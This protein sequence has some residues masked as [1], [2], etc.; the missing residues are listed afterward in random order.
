MTISTDTRVAPRAVA[1]VRSKVG[2][3]RFEIKLVSEGR[4]LGHVPVWLRLHPEGFSPTYPLR[5]VNS[6]YFDT[7]DLASVEAN[8]AGISERR[9]LRLRWYGETRE[10]VRG[11]WELKHKRAG[12]GWKVTQPVAHDIRLD[13]M[14]WDQV[15]HLLRRTASDTIAMDLAT[16]SAATLINSYEREY[17][18]SADGAVR[19]TVDRNQAAYEQRLSTRPN[20]TRRSPLRDG[21]VVELKAAPENYDRLVDAAQ[22]LPMR[23]TRNSKYVN[24]MLAS[25][26]R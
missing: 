18:E 26:V 14:T 8:L 17:F 2:E 16:V 19:A 13:V 11:T 5:R 1:T 23:V 15:L 3:A 4:D 6:I 9:K 25:V 24:G 10:V 21:L 20:L 7:P 12:L 22:R